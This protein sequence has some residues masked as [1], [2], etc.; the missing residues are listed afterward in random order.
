MRI[1]L[2]SAMANNEKIDLQF[3]HQLIFRIICFRL[4]MA[5]LEDMILSNTIS[6][7]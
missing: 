3:N 1:I 6:E 4:S 5:I 2:E 7:M